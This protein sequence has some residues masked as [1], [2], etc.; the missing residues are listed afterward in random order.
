MLQGVGRRLANSKAIAEFM[1]TNPLSARV[2]D[3]RWDIW[4]IPIEPPKYRP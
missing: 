1:E 3:P 4:G 2:W